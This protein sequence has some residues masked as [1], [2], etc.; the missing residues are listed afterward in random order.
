MKLTP[1]QEQIEIIEAVQTGKDVIV[2]A[3]AGA[4]KTTTCV[5]IAEQTF[6]SSLYLTFNK[7]MQEEAE[8]KMP[9]HVEVRT[10]HSVAFRASGVA[11]AH[12]LKRPQGRYQ[13]VC[14]TGTEI[15]NYFKLKNIFHE[16]R[17]VSANALGLA[18][19]ETLAKY[20]YS[21]DAQLSRKHLSYT[22]LRKFFVGGKI[23]KDLHDSFSEVVLSTAKKLWELRINPDNEIVI[24]H[25]T[26]LKVFQLSGQSLGEYDIIYSDESQDSSM[27][28][29]DVLR[30]Q[31]TQRVIVGDAFQKIYGWRGSVNAMKLF[32]GIE[33]K[34]SKSFRFG[35]EVANIA[36]AI[37][38]MDLE[39]NEAV[40][41]EVHS[42]EDFELVGSTILY[43]TNSALLR[44]ACQHIRAGYRVNLEIDARD[45]SRL[46][47][48]VV[49][50]KENN[51]RGV[52]HESVMPYNSWEE[53][54]TDVKNGWGAEISNVVGIVSKG[55]HHGI[56]N[57]LK[58]HVNC[59][60]PEVVMTTAHK[61]KGREFDVVVL[62]D[63]FPSGYDSDKVWVGLEEEERNLLYVATTRAKHLLFYNKT[64]E[65]VYNRSVRSGA[66][67]L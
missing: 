50:L 1:T 15:A 32:N 57:T 4:A 54:V 64:V 33:L 65:N 59:N 47:E 25:D 28:M 20:E 63:D 48:S 8:E 11:L 40:I 61:S 3:L 58:H 42:S 43:R 14:G 46:M 52:K 45:F 18:V 53:L 22:V 35:T 2:Q 6:K 55:Q 12:K 37:I 66:G 10:W 24:T 16:T 56:L 30:K 31:E 7:R 17:F 34:L 39:G 29:I 19:K 5:L 38:D 62:A 60:N 23:P 41:S 36:S 51:K 27:V 13:N 49:A 26:Y 44:D 9:P 67:F 21:E